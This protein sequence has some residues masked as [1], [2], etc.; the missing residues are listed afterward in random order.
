M[1]VE[2]ISYPPRMGRPPG[3]LPGRR[4][5][6]AVTSCCRLDRRM[7]VRLEAVVGEEIGI[8]IPHHVI[9][10]ILR[11]EELAENQP[12]K[13]R[14]RKW[15]RYERRYSNSLWHTDYKQ[16]HDGRWFVSYQ[17]DASRL[18]VSFGVFDEPA[19]DHAIEVLEEAVKRYGKPAQILTD[20]GSQFYANERANS[21]RGVAVFESRLV[22][23]GI[24]QVMARIRHPQTN[25]KLGR[26]HSEIE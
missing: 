4:E 16:L 7:A 8:H 26:F 22:E 23:M 9:H 19:G 15:V 3:G 13:A 14:Q 11:D 17:N 21:R 25:G 18:I 12:G 1:P 24:R 5:H 20:H 6:S 10:D 2:E